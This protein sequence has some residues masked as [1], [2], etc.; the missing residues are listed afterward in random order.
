[1][2]ISKTRSVSRV[3]VYPPL[4]DS[5]PRIMVVYEYSFDD[6]ED[7]ELPANSTSVKHLEA[8]DSEG[9]AT[10]VTGEDQLVQDIAGAVWS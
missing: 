5:Q 2:A 6:T 10:D 8:T 9:N 1:M 3:E 7:D 4:D